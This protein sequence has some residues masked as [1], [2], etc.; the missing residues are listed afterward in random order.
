[1]LYNIVIYSLGTAAAATME[2]LQT[3]YLFG[4]C[5]SATT[6]AGGQLFC[7]IA[8]RRRR[9]RRQAR[10]LLVAIARSQRRRQNERYV[11][12]GN[13][14]FD[15]DTDTIGTETTPAYDNMAL[16]TRIVIIMLLHDGLPAIN[17]QPPA[18]CA[19]RSRASSSCRA[20][21]RY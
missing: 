5:P 21:D 16:C 13:G 4:M 6:S 20:R 2:R 1:M 14:Y 7:R 11:P 8:L 17:A 9:R 10:K 18:H 3:T 15:D 12:T 19:T